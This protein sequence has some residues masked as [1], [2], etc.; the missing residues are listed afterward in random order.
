[1]LARNNAEIAIIV[2]S[3]TTWIIRVAS[4]DQSLVG[5]IAPNAT[6]R[7]W[8]TLDGAWRKRA[9]NCDAFTDSKCVPTSP[10][11]ITGSH[12]LRFIAVSNV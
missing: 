9:R 11:A 2:N 7:E 5:P 3:S 4:D 1:M 8:A 10:V 12:G 6:S